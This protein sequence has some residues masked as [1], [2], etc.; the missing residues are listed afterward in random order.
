MIS[1]MD[2][3]YNRYAG[4]HLHV[5]IHTCCKLVCTGTPLLL[6]R[7]GHVY[8]KGVSNSA[9]GIYEEDSTIAPPSTL[10]VAKQMFKCKFF[11][12]LL[13]L[14]VHKVVIEKVICFNYYDFVI[15]SKLTVTK[16]RN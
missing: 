16:Y 1:A 11:K 8:V 9:M 12:S 6:G 3:C 10:V 14:K 4:T 2:V 15:S 5:N 13:T 7:K